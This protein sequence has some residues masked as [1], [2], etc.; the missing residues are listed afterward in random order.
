MVIVVI[1]TQLRADADVTA[2]ETAGARMDELV[3][4]M[5]GFVSAKDFASDDGDHISLVTFDSLEALAAWRNQ[6]EH[7]EVQRRGREEFYASYSVQVCE[8]VRAYSFP[9]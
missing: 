5:P 7:L 3:R 4:A 1:R 8:V 6:P 2:Y 9:G